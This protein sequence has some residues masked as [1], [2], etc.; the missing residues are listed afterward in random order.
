MAVHTALVFTDFPQI[1]EQSGSV[2]HSPEP[3]G[4][5]TYKWA[6]NAALK[7]SAFHKHP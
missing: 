1:A 6:G 4:F 3:L 7:S 2:C 5:T